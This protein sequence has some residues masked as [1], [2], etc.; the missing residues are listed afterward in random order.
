MEALGSVEGQARFAGFGVDELALASALQQVFAPVTAADKVASRLMQRLSER[1]VP[2]RG[3]RWTEALRARKWALVTSVVAACIVA[4]L[5]LFSGVLKRPVLADTVKQLRQAKVLL[6][7]LTRYKWEE[8]KVEPAEVMQGKIW[9]RGSQ[10]FMDL[11]DRKQWVLDDEVVT[12]FPATKRVVMSKASED[13]KVDASLFSVEQ[14]VAQ[15]ES[16]GME[17]LPEE[18]ETI[19]GKEYVCLRLVAEPEAHDVELVLYIDPENGRL[20]YVGYRIAEGRHQGRFHN[21]MKYTYNPDI[22]DKVFEPSYPSDA[23][24]ERVEPG[25]STDD[26]IKELRKQALVTA[27]EP[28]GMEVGVLE[29]WLAPDGKLFLHLYGYS[30]WIWGT[31][32]RDQVFPEEEQTK[33]G[34]T[35]KEW[36]NNTPFVLECPEGTAH[37]RLGGIPLINHMFH[38]PGKGRALVEFRSCYYIPELLAKDPPKEC[39]LHVWELRQPPS[40]FHWS[41]NY[42]RNKE[43]WGY[44][45]LRVPAP[46]KAKES[47]SERF[48]NG[49]VPASE[50]LDTQTVAFRAWL[51][52]RNVG[53]EKALALLNEQPVEV[54]HKL[55]WNK[56]KLLKKLGRQSE[57][58]EFLRI[59]LAWMKEHDK[60]Y[61]SNMTKLLEKFA[62]PS[63]KVE[64]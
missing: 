52:E 1:P 12:Y 39:T 46:E 49:M 26:T 42:A 22:D 50:R 59:H 60:Y 64:E 23:R 25:R 32:R 34:F 33:G 4:T 44:L 54:Q 18:R 24:I 61:E 27:T 9:I 15:L 8:T 56:L 17:K 47:P 37:Q 55:A 36:R 57:I 45:T 11:P 21:W 51:L 58:D 41:E 28:G 13:M 48:I 6:I 53:P 20:R 43:S 2:C 29:V 35:A 7:E 38:F 31:T 5:V 40:S 63:F 14:L 30:L 3:A 62:S 19:E 10:V 16:A